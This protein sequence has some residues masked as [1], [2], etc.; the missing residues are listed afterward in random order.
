MDKLGASPNLK[1]FF[2]DVAQCL[3]ATVHFLTPCTRAH[4]DGCLVLCH[5][6]SRIAAWA[7]S[8]GGGPMS[9]SMRC[10]L[11]ASLL[12][13][14]SGASFGQAPQTALPPAPIPAS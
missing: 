13:W 14:A 5:R 10:L 4:L 3:V 8:P 7:F 6:L 12:G 2:D 9:T 11:V 1:S